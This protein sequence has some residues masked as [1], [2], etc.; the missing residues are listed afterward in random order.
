MGLWDSICETV[1][2]V[3]NT[4][5]GYGPTLSDGLIGDLVGSVKDAI[6]E[7]P[8]KTVAIVA[9]TVA[10]GG[11]ALAAAPAI[12]TTIGGAGVL[13]AASTGTA[14]GSL[15]GAALTNASLAALGGGAL[16]AG[17]G[18]MAAGATVIAGAGAAVGGG[19]AAITV[20]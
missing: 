8:G 14:I 13:G 19:V 2:A 5:F 18:G 17:G 1:E 9:A 11:V 3:D 15:S 20:E 10:T 16:A 6:T 4:L 7:N 12:A